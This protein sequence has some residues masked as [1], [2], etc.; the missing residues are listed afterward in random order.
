MRFVVTVVVPAAVLVVEV[1]P[2]Q[3]GHRLVPV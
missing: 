3:P 2:A 1:G